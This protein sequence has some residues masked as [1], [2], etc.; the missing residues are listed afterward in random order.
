MNADHKSETLSAATVAFA[1]TEHRGRIVDIPELTLLGVT[2]L[3][4]TR[5]DGI[6]QLRLRRLRPTPKD[7]KTFVRDGEE[8]VVDKTI[9]R[10]CTP[11]GGH[12]PDNLHVGCVLR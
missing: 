8:I 11:V 10:A 1:I 7:W 6:V 4:A 5:T 12:A 2:L 9:P 3:D